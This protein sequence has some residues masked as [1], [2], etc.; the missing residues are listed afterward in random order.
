VT[1]AVESVAPFLDAAAVVVAPIR[2]GG[3]MRV[4]LLEAMAAGKAIVASPLAAAGLEVTDGHELLLAGRDSEFAAAIVRLLDDPMAR[5]ALARRAR[6]W[7]ST[8]AGWENSL[9]KYEALQRELLQRSDEQSRQQ[10]SRA[11]CSADSNRPGGSSIVYTDCRTPNQT[12][13]VLTSDRGD[14]E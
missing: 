8:H 7:A 11:G 6:A 12:T 10:H 2:N 9:S 13:S 3:G 1:G 4:K 5:G 14:Y